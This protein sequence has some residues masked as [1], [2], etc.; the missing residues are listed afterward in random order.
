MK[1]AFTGSTVFSPARSTSG[2]PSISADPAISMNPGMTPSTAAMR[3]P[4][5]SPLDLKPRAGISAWP[6]GGAI[7]GHVY[8]QG[9]TTP[10][11]GMDVDLYADRCGGG[12]Q[13]RVQTDGSGYFAFTGLPFGAQYILRAETFDNGLNYVSQW[14]DQ[15]DATKDCNT[16]AF[17]SVGETIVFDLA[18][19]ARISGQVADDSGT[20][21]ENVHVFITDAATGQWLGGTNTDAGG[22]FHLSGLPAGDR[23]V[24]VC[25]SCN[26]LPYADE[27]YNNSYSRASATPISLTPGSEVVLE[28]IR[29]AAAKTIGG[30]ISGLD[31]GQHVHISAANDDGTLHGE[32]DLQFGKGFTADEYGIVNYTVNV[33]PGQRYRVTTFPDGDPVVYYREGFPTGTFS[34]NLASLVDPSDN[35]TNINVEVT[36]GALL[37]GSAL[38]SG[39]S[40]AWQKGSVCGLMRNTKTVRERIIRTI[41]TLAWKSGETAPAQTRSAWRSFPA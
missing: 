23:L 7:S 1:P 38:L 36:Q 37:S 12:H 35:P 8:Q 17:V 39:T 2:Q 4:S 19:G 26:D 5:Q 10:I 32:G 34:W 28:E 11:P 3:R 24:H 20:P 18:P 9:T 13:R 31:P 27:I 25:P 22:A 41:S 15:V 16:A 21:I 33:L 14:Y 40:M 30:I 6:S 29:L